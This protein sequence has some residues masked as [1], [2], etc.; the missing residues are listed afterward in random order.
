MV[1]LGALKLIVLGGLKNSERKDGTDSPGKAKLLKSTRRII[2]MRLTAVY[3]L[4]LPTVKVAFVTDLLRMTPTI[5]VADVNGF[6]SVFC[7]KRNGDNLS[8][9]ILG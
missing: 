1:E 4:Y 7:V 3:S 5:V 6:L 8:L 2:G 9:E